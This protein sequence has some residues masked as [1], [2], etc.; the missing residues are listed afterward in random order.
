MTTNKNPCASKTKIIVN[1]YIPKPNKNNTCMKL[2]KSMVEVYKECTEF[3]ESIYNN[4][5]MEVLACMEVS[6]SIYKWNIFSL[7]SLSC[8]YSLHYEHINTI[9]KCL[10]ELCNGLLLT[11]CV[12]L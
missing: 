7:I 6:E 12:E 2:S 8:C 4:S 9:E 3:S 10:G 5:I 11:E 1:D